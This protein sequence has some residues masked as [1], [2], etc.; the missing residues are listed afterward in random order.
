MEDKT[1][2]I[3]IQTEGAKQT[4]GIHT[5]ITFEIDDKKNA[6]KSSDGKN[7]ESSETDD[8]VPVYRGTHTE[9][10]S[11]NFNRRRDP[12][13]YGHGNFYE[14][15]DNDD[16]FRYSDGGNWVRFLPMANGGWTT[17]RYSETFNPQSICTFLNNV[18]THSKLF[19][20]SDRRIPSG[21]FVPYGIGQKSL[22]P[23]ICDER[24]MWRDVNRRSF[25]SSSLRPVGTDDKLEYPFSETD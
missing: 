12:N 9:G 2:T 6:T 3:R 11:S 8:E 15:N 7:A 14:T 16:G 10:G 21:G 5:D 19:V 22:R 24:P 20:F 17:E 4:V 23:C 18:K 1:E 25:D 13:Y